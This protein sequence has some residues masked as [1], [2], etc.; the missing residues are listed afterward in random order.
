[1]AARPPEKSVAV[2]PPVENTMEKVKSAPIRSRIRDGVSLSMISNQADR[3]GAAGSV[4]ATSSVD[5]GE[6]GREEGLIAG[7]PAVRRGDRGGLEQAGPPA[8]FQDRAVDHLGVPVRRVAQDL[9]TAA[10]RVP[11][12]Q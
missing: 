2:S 7:H 11:A 12:G 6:R 1:M 4:I 9:V 10:D 3:K 8:G 5:Q